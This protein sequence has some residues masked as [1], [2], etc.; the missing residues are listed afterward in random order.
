MKKIYEL[1]QEHNSV[2]SRMQKI[3]DSCMKENRS[4]THSE[5]SE[6]EKL[7]RQLKEITDAIDLAQYRESQT[8]QDVARGMGISVNTTKE[9]AEFRSWFERSVSGET[10]ENFKVSFRADPILTTTNTDIA[11]KTVL[12]EKTMYAPAEEMLKSLGITFHPGV[13]GNLVLPKGTETTA[14]FVGETVDASSAD[15]D[16]DAITLT[17]K[18]VTHTQSVTREALSTTPQILESIFENLYKGVWNAVADRFFDTVDTACSAQEFSIAD[19]TLSF[20]DIVKQEAKLGR[21]NLEKPAYVMAPETKA[22]CK[23]TAAL[24]NQAAIWQNNVVNEYPA[25][26]TPSVNGEKVYFGDWKLAHIADFSG[27][28]IIVDPFSDAKKGIIKFTAVALFDMGVQNPEAFSIID[29]AST[30]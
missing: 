30:F 20:K 8:L 10:K 29:D 11:L 28:E 23:S 15:M 5:I 7:D 18:R 9:P 19:T 16:F 1:K 25:F 4:K 26:S 22:H 27:L 3:V 2:I 13:K 21:W 6:Y 14:L 17:G 24:S 12:R